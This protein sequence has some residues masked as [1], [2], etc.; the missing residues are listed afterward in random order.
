MKIVSY[1][2]KKGACDS[3]YIANRT[4]KKCKLDDYKQF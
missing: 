2:S 1:L 3:L 4:D